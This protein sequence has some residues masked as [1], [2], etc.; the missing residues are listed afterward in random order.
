MSADNRDAKAAKAAK[1]VDPRQISLWGD[2]PA[3]VSEKSE[4]ESDNQGLARND[5]PSDAEETHADASVFISASDS[6]PSPSPSPAS[7]ASANSKAAAAQHD[8]FAG[9]PPLS[10]MSEKEAKEA[11]IDQSAHAANDTESRAEGLKRYA[12]ENATARR[13]ALAQGALD[14]EPDLFADF[15][16]EPAKTPAREPAASAASTAAGPVASAALSDA[17]VSDTAKKAAKT[18]AASAAKPGGSFGGAFAPKY[19]APQTPEGWDE[20]GMELDEPQAAAKPMGLSTPTP[21]AAATKPYGSF[22]ALGAD[23]AGQKG[24]DLNAERRAMDAASA[25][26]GGFGRIWAPKAISDES[27]ARMGITP[28]DAGKFHPITD[29]DSILFIGDPH[30]V[31]AD[32]APGRRLDAAKMPEVIA[33]KL[34]QAAAIA[35]ARRARMAILGDLFD[36]A[37][38]NGLTMLTLAVKALG[39]AT[40]QPMTLV[41]NHEKLHERVTDNTALGLVQAAG[42]LATLEGNALFEVYEIDGQFIGLGG[43]GHG[44][45]IPSDLRELKSALSLDVLIWMTHHDLAFGGAYPGAAP[46]EEILGVDLLVNGHMHLFKKPEKRGGMLAW[47]PG[48]ITRMEIGSIEH[49]PAVWLWT[50]NKR[51]HLEKIVLEYNKDVF[52]RTGKMTVAKEGDEAT[53]RAELAVEESL[54]AMMLRE[55]DS[56]DKERTTD[57]SE[58]WED[59]REIFEARDAAPAVRMAVVELLRESLG[60]F[61]PSTARGYADIWSEQAKQEAELPA[62]APMERVAKAPAAKKST[63]KSKAVL[64]AEAALANTSPAAARQ[65]MDLALAADAAEEVGVM[66]S[67]AGLPDESG[68]EQNPSDDGKAGLEGNPPSNENDDEPSGTSEE[69]EHYRVREQIDG[70]HTSSDGNL[71]ADMPPLQRK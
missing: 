66:S 3:S 20:P 19:A 32:R 44:N 27:F 25:A 57:A 36:Q 30:M 10:A 67:P 11:K 68:N 7:L 54:F 21:V 53:V 35:R 48:N 8:L 69:P 59:M 51:Q 62:L 47:N 40:H 43:S 13:A 4:P 71:W 5:S 58:L 34:S 38:D 1:A 52:N 18:L 9:E 28:F 61:L 41:G 49:E 39:Q 45:L 17:P 26:T 63:A 14:L 29:F 24:R 31:S 15:A 56:Q 60:G 37:D 12:Q 42:A 2:E 55:Q 6:P 64:A 16:E 70:L 22:G 50:P 23:S 65:Q 46:I 33:D